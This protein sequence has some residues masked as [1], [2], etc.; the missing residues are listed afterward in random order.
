MTKPDAITK[1]AIGGREKWKAV[2]EGRE[3]TTR[4]G[5]FCVRLPDEDERARHITTHE[6]QKLATAFFDATDPWSDMKDRSRFGVP[7]FV[8]NISELLVN[9]I[10]KKYVHVKKIFF[11]P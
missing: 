2:L 11:K 10:E 6:A 7:N 3:H 1:G 5:Y 4:H 8:A 9:L